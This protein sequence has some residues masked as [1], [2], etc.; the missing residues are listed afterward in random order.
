MSISEQAISGEV[1]LLR[2]LAA[3]YNAEWKEEAAMVFSHAAD[4]IEALTAKLQAANMDRSADCSGW[5][6]CSTG[7]MPDM[8]S[9]VLIQFKSDMN[10]ITGD[11]DRTFDISFIRSRDNREWFCSTGKYPLKAVKAWKPIKSYHEP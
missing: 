4:T 3:S 7:N 2:K 1:D 8:G 5:I 9:A 6:P 10:G 11:D